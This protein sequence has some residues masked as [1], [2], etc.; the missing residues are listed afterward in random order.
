MTA[1]LPAPELRPVRPTDRPRVVEITE[2]VWDG[3]DYLPSVFD[4]WVTDPGG[5]FQAA[6]LEGMLVG[7][8]RVRPIGPG[9][10][11][12]EGLRVD[13]GYRRRGL[14]RAMVRQAMADAAR[15]G[16]QEM[17]VTTGDEA[18]E[19]LFEGEGF[20]ARARS[21]RWTAPRREGGDPPRLASGAD[22]GRLARVVAGDATGAAYGG[23][24]AGWQ[25][26]LDVDAALIERMADDGWVRLGP[27]G[28]AFALLLQP[29][30]D[31]LVVGFIAGVGA[32]LDELLEALRFE[33]DSQALGGVTLWLPDPYPAADHIT[34]VG[35]HLEDESTRCTA[36]VRRL[37]Q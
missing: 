15:Q 24:L 5:Q 36:Y 7:V 37:M 27:G 19:R 32:A 3:N 33:A 14:A 13:A 29:G 16:F 20:E 6:E 17:R 23:V 4:L 34:A 35:Y 8:H 28:R 26:P 2:E 11:L 31:R 1:E 21:R 9:V 10:V 12:Y 30:R 22:A 25:G 18:G